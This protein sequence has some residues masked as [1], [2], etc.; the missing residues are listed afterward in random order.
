MPSKIRKKSQGRWV[1]PI[2][3]Y[4]PRTEKE[5]EYIL[6]HMPYQFTNA[7][8]DTERLENILK[9]FRSFGCQPSVGR[10]EKKWRFYVNVGTEMY[11]ESDDLMTSFRKAFKKW[12]KA[13]RP[14]ADGRRLSVHIRERKLENG[15][16]RLPMWRA[17]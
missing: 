9:T 5:K 7:W 4:S 8:R 6:L 13:G 16:E 17:L 11:E 1:C 15:E 2:S 14:T 10:R 3:E 12:E